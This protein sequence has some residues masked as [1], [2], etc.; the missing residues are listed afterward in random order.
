MSQSC[1]EN[2]CHVPAQSQQGEALEPRPA[3]DEWIAAQLAVAPPLEEWQE[4]LLGA[5]FSYDC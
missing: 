2:S 4:K 5:L 1:L 3:I